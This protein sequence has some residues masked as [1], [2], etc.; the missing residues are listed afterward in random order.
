MC[1]IIYILSYSAT[2]TPNGSVSVCVG[3]SVQ[4][5]C[6][7]PMGVIAWYT[8]GVDGVPN[9][10]ANSAPGLDSLSRFSSPD[11]DN[12]VN[13][14][15]ITL[16]NVVLSDEGAAIQ[17]QGSDGSRSETTIVAVGN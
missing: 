7:G 12:T 11:S 10:T 6:N 14:S 3:N 16:L 15:R 9:Q 5:K 17:C 4:F 2:L 8:T 1:I 13:P